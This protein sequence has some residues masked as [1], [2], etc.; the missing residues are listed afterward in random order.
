M[1]EICVRITLLKLNAILF[2]ENLPKTLN[3]ITRHSEMQCTVS[4]T[5]P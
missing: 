5:Q 2:G 3:L 1:S 4:L